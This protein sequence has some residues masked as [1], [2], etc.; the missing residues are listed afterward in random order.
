MAVATASAKLFANAAIKGYDFDPGTTN[1]TDIAWVDMRDYGLFACSFFR[2][3]G[4]GALDGFTILANTQ[5]DGGGTDVEIKAHAVGSEPNAVGDQLFLECT[6]EE[7]KT[8]GANYRYV[9]ASCE[10]ATDSDEGVVTYIR[11]K[12]RFPAD[13]LT[14]DIVA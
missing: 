5:S 14:A 4:T 9:S 12:P 8:A 3:V 6:A 13:G 1:A 2:T 10:F 11:S 7:I